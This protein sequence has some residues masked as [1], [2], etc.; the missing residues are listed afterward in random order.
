MT[1]LHQAKNRFHLK[2]KTRRVD[3]QLKDDGTL[4][5]LKELGILSSLNLFEVMVHITNGAMY[6]VHVNEPHVIF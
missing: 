1:S 6:C 5:I 4:N 3:Y 2:E